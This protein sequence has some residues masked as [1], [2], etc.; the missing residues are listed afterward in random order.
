MFLKTIHK[1]WIYIV[2]KDRGM[3]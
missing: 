1:L 2:M 3:C